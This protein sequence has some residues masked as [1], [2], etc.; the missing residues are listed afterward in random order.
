MLLL[1]PG[2]EEG[3][4]E[5]PAVSALHQEDTTRRQPLHAGLGVLS[6]AVR[7]ACSKHLPLT[8]RP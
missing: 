1:G 3:W 4:E 8:L 7:E 5:D 6:G 2:W